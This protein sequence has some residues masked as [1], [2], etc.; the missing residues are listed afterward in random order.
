MTQRGGSSL[1]RWL[2][3]PSVAIKDLEQIRQSRLLAS[4][5]IPLILAAAFFSIGESVGT[6]LAE[7]LRD[8]DM[9]LT[10]AALGLMIV[11]YL[12]NRA[13]LY[14]LAATLTVCMLAIITLWAGAPSGNYS[15]IGILGYQILNVL[16]ASALLPYP[17]DTGY[18]CIQPYRYI[19]FANLYS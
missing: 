15:D 17:F 13:S 1:W 4:L 3:A 18:H 16:L 7:I 10:W 11:A 6:P 19:S 5:L 2:T 8:G 9:V 12:L 14:R